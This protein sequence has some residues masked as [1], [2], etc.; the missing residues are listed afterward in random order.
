MKKIWPYCEAPRGIEAV[1]KIEKVDVRGE[2]I[3]ELASHY[4]CPV[5]RGDLEDPKKGFDFLGKA[6]EEY[7]RRHG[8]THPRRL[9]PSG[10]VT[11]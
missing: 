3:E 11:A 6:Y 10:N 5:C 8:L 1:E 7:G 4:H 9:K 2:S